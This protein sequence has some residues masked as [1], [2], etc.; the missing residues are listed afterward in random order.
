MNMAHPKNFMTGK[1]TTAIIFKINN[2][3]RHHQLCN[4]IPLETTKKSRRED[5]FDLPFVVC[6]QEYSL[7]N[8]TFM[9][10]TYSVKNLHCLVTKI[11][12]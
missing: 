8:S 3:P 12:F 9:T 6:C 11:F 10:Y 7:C 1:L 2:Q 5:L 4:Q